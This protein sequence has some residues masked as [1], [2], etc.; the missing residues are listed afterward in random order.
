MAEEN[1]EEFHLDVYPAR[2]ELHCN[3]RKTVFREGRQSDG[4]RSR[5]GKVTNRLEN[6]YLEEMYLK[7]GDIDTSGLPERFKE[8]LKELVDGVTSETGRALAGLAF[9]QI[10]IK[11]IVPDQ[12]VRLHKG[13]AGGGGFSWTEG[14]SMRAIDSNYN[15][16]FLREKGL[17]N[18]NRSGIMMTRSLAENYPYSRLY[19]AEM[20]GPFDSWISIVDELETGAVD[21]TAALAYMMS[22]LIDRSNKFERTAEDALVALHSC[23][24]F[25]FNA[26][27]NLLVRFFTDT[28]YSAR[29]FEVVIH[30]F[31]QAYVKMR[32][33]D[34]NIVPMSQMRT[35]NKKH[36][37]VG[38]IELK[39]GRKIIEAWD[40]KFGKTYL[41]DELDEL[42]DKLEA[43]PSVSLAGFIVNDRLDLKA[44]IGE[45]ADEVS[46][47][48]DTDIRLYTFKE[49]VDF[50][51]EEVPERDRNAFA[52]EWMTAVVESFARRRP[53]VAPIDEPCEEWLNDLRRLIHAL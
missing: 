50:K 21:C 39:E 32:Y 48:T 44:E 53:D 13:S 51:L 26:V 45:K 37:N 27:E 19:K 9:L 5:Y 34:L 29:A 18:I 49:W 41:Y 47:A 35:A 31:M 22:L 38:D 52:E 36:G 6:G 30:A 10:T 46:M 17:L 1:Y 28:K 24:S 11:S 14:I 43:N 33:S 8:R 42:K 4:A 25:D 3:G 23:R 40:A 12:S 20:R 2:S 15:A 16:P 7:C